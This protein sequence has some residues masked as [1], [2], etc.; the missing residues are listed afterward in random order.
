MARI[1]A[2]HKAMTATC[3]ACQH[4]QLR[5]GHLVWITKDG[6][7]TCSEICAKRLEKSRAA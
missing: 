1:T 5:P 3:P 2:Y 4:N 7:A 6:F